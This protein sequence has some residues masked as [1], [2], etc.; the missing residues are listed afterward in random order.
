M[1]VNP[2]IKTCKYCGSKYNKETTKDCM[3]CFGG[4]EVVFAKKKIASRN[5]NFMGYKKAINRTGDLIKGIEKRKSY[6]DIIK[7][8]NK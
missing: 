2:R 5:R 6:D 3:L 1:Y 7:E 8:I 4:K